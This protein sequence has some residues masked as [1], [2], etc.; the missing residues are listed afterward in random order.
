V[1]EGKVVLELAKTAVVC[2]SLAVVGSVEKLG[3]EEVTVEELNVIVVLGVVDLG[4]FVEGCSVV[5][6]VGTVVRIVVRLDVVR[7]VVVAVFNVV[8][9]GV[10]GL[11]LR[12]FT[13]TGTGRGVTVVIVRGV[14]LRAVVFGLV[15]RVVVR[16]VVDGN[17]VVLIVVRLV[18]EVD[19]L[20]LGVVGS[21]TS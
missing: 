20:R 15:E 19:V 6:V 18:V 17:V 11:V 12:V 13:V 7:G 2:V 5:L 10:T 14:V 8:D 1:V 21:V 3:V 9:A 4:V 16:R